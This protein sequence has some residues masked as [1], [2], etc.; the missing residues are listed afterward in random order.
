MNIKYVNSKDLKQELIMAGWIASVSTDKTDK[1]DDFYLNVAKHC[2]LSN[3]GT[4]TRS[5]RFVFEINDISR[6]CANEFVRHE[7][8][9]TK[10]QKSQR[11]VNEEDFS[12]Y[13]PVSIVKSGNGDMY[14]LLMEAVKEQYT[15]L[16][17]AGVPKEDARYVLPNATATSLHVAF[18]W[19]SLV[20]FLRRRRCLRAQK[21][22]RDIANAIAELVGSELDNIGL[23]EL[24]KFLQAPCDFYGKCPEAKPCGKKVK[25]DN[26]IPMVK[27]I[28]QPLKRV[29]GFEPV[30]NAPKDVIIPKRSTKGS[31]GHDFF[32]PYD[33]L[34]PAHGTSELVFSGI[35]AYM[36]IDEF[37][38]NHIRSSLAIKFGLSLVNKTCIIDSDY[39]NNEK[40]EG[41]IG[42]MFRNDSDKDYIIKKGEKMAQGIFCKYYITDDDNTDGVRD[43]GFGST[44]K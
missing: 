35:K 42:F 26:I 31:A 38:S 4:P 1:N 28:K 17:K 2:I 30:S 34:V 20:N 29:R 32:A 8:G 21:E 18:N 40:N 16:I 6:A 23:G 27:E 9:V 3:H 24:K 43:G 19:E 36:P 12:Y 44:G 5:M 41:N 25:T 7:I 13:L 14:K 22:I 10:V 15:D 39:Y 37:L 33:I 11:Y